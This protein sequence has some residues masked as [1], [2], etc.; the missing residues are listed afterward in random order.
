MTG[1]KT[2]R[3]PAVTVCVCLLFA[4]GLVPAASALAQ[5]TAPSATAAARP[6]NFL[7]ILADDLGAR[8]LACYGHKTHRTPNVDALARSGVMFRMCWATPMCCPSRAEMLTGRYGVRTGW[9]NQMYHGPTPRDHLDPNEITFASVLKSRGYATGL[10]GKW[11]LGSI[12]TRPRMILENGFDEYHAWAQFALPPGARFDGS[13]DQK[14]WHPALIENGRF[15]PTTPRDYGPDLECR[16]LIDFMRRHRD[17]PFLAYWPMCLPHEP[18]EPTPNASVPDGRRAGGLQGSIEY[19]DTLVGRIVVALDELKLRDNTII[20]FCGDNGP[21]EA[22]KGELTE[23]GVRV[24]MIV[25]GPGVQR[26]GVAIEDLVDLSDVLPTLADLAGAATP[27]GIALDGRSF[28]PALR[29]I[30]GQGRAWIASFMDDRAIIRT[31]R[32]LLEG[33]GKLYDCHDAG[34][35]RRAYR[36]VTDS[37]A[38]EVVDAR[39]NLDSILS[40]LPMPRKQPAGSAPAASQTHRGGD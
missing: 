18:H 17:R 16:W 32:W 31:A 8:H 5:T 14:Y 6:P 13:L 39:R 26:R 20:L 28:A 10:A 15:V 19:M 27:R 34:T 33:D 7:V 4:V 2:T 1:G 38:P 22:G 3:P 24:P 37:R 21:A 36:D 40:R 35:G 23:P 30:R 12:A 11:H 29:G 9:L 25:A